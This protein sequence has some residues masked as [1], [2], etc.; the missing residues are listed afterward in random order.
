MSFSISHKSKVGYG[1]YT[2]SD[3]SRIL[4]F[5]LQKVS[6]YLN[7]YWDKKSG[8]D[9]FKDTYSWS[10]DNKTKAVNFYVLIELYTFI[11]LQEL[12][13]PTQKIFKARQQI[14][15][16]LNTEYPFA[17]AGI[18][19]DGKKILYEVMDDIIDSDGTRQINIS[20]IIHDFVKRIDFNSENKLAERFYPAG[21]N[22]SIVVDPHHQ[23]GLPVIK[24]TNIN[25]D[26]IYSMYSSGEPVNSIG[27]LYDLT[28]KQVK[29]IVQFHEKNAA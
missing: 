5:P 17:S 12:G 1:I 16:D 13:V 15:K 8:K 14:A 18:L 4:G 6:R 26:V 3:I 22:K 19:T 23:F 24:G 11:S 27:I 28:K 25:T 21:K 2:A 10:I 29:D 7:L 9:M 20:K